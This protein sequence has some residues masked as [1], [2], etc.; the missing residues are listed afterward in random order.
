MNL[1]AKATEKNLRDAAT[2]TELYLGT[3]CLDA[4]RDL[5]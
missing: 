5:N 2:A 3:T 4:L 1:Y